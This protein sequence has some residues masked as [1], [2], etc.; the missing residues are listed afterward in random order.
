[1]SHTPGPWE[2]MID[3]DNGL[4]R[5]VA[6]PCHEHQNCGK[7]IVFIQ[8]DP[9]RPFQSST[10]EHMEGNARLIAAA[11]ALLEAAKEAEQILDGALRSPARA[12][13]LSILKAAIAKAEGAQ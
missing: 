10:G 2:L 8:R 3:A 4:L 7:T 9:T 13:V 5:E 1:M 11:P 6:A 12:H